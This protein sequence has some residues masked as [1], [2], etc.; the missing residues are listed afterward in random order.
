MRLLRALTALGFAAF[1]VCLSCRPVEAVSAD[2]V[3]AEAEEW[4]V[5]Y[6]QIGRAHV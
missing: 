2:P 4:L 1:A 5:Q 3:E 6:L